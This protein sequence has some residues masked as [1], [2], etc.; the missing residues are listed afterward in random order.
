MFWVGGLGHYHK[1]PGI[2]ALLSIRVAKALLVATGL[3]GV[4]AGA[5]RLLLDSDWRA[6]K[7]HCCKRQGNRKQIRLRVNTHTHTHRESGLYE[8]FPYSLLPTILLP[9]GLKCKS[10]HSAQDSFLRASQNP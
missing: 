5:L 6:V 7:C 3:A 4:G 10:K 8:L 9:L 1:L 2:K